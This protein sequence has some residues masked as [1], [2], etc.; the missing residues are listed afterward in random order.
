MIVSAERK[1]A[2]SARILMVLEAAARVEI[3]GVGTGKMWLP[4]MQWNELLIEL[5]LAQGA[6]RAWSIDA[7]EQQGPRAIVL[8]A[9]G[10]EV[11]VFCNPKLGEYELDVGVTREFEWPNWW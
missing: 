8:S 5:M 4:A 11:R 3:E 10:R 1:S 6:T 7:Q 2:F 9:A